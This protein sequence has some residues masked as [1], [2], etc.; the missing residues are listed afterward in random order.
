MALKLLVQAGLFTRGA[1]LLVDDEGLRRVNFRMTGRIRK[2]SSESSVA[3][4]GQ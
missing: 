1:G 2:E 4:K 3:G